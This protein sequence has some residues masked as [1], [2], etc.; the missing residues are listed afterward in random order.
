MQHVEYL[1][2]GAG[3]A[4]LQLGYYMQRDNRDYLLLERNAKAGSSFEV[5]PKHRKLI[6]IN[7]VFTG[8][9][10]PELKLR[11][12][13]NSLLTDEFD[14][15]FSDFDKEYF[16]HPDN[17]C[18][19]LN[20]FAERFNI[21]VKYNA[22][23]KLVE[24]KDDGYV[25]TLDGGEQISCK[26]LI[27]ATG[28]SKPFIPDIPG[29]EL[30]TQY[31]DLN[32]DL[33]PYEDKMA[34]IIGKGNSGFE[35]ADHLISACR[36]IHIC[37]PTPLVLAWKSHF[38]GNLRAVNN[39]FLDTYQLKSQNAVLDAEI[40][41]IEK[42]GDKFA[43]TFKYVQANEVEEI[44]YDDVICCT[45]FRLDVDIFD[46]DTQP[47]MT[48]KGRFPELSAEWES[49]NQPN[50]YF[51]GT[52]TQSR[53]YKKANSGFIHGFRYNVKALYKMLAAKNHGVEWE[54]KVVSADPAFVAK[55]MLAHLNDS[56][57][58]WQQSSFIGNCYLV[59]PDGDHMRYFADI[60]TD[61]VTEKVAG[62]HAHYYMVTLEFGK[63][64]DDPFDT[65]R[66]AGDQVDEAHNSNFLHPVVRHYKHGEL[67]GEHHII[68][69]L[70]GEWKLEK[71]HMMPLKLF[72]N[73]QMQMA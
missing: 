21:K 28:V 29:I 34:L 36:T 53:D 10:N 52:I 42:R 18:A 17:M 59:E 61:Y 15:I 65:R 60:P 16:P 25:L 67:L 51:A 19:Y 38:V 40:T 20:S 46:Q 13:W 33:K 8:E 7:K 70:F 54:S 68:E 63:S 37:S 43:V 35:T 14:A 48:I 44:V 12:D 4:G 11:H 72:L 31:E 64:V 57:A 23:A 27:V 47:Q 24:K 73:K 5:Y 56:S 9:T 1:I 49:V 30:V 50:M 62:D 45:G 66:P 3:P 41:K 6:S 58:L 22:L 26:H 71:E 2:L 39:N 69:N 32:I 55:D